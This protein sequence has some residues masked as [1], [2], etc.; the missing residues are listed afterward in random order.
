MVNKDVD[1]YWNCV[2]RMFEFLFRILK[3]LK[4]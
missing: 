3:E 2:Y 4:F 1:R